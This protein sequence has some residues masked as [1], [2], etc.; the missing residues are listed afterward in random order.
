MVRA[1]N[2]VGYYSCIAA[3]LTLDFSSGLNR[4]ATPTLFVSGAADHLGGPPEIMAELAAS[5][6]GA[7]HVSVPHAARIANIQNSSDFNTILGK[8]LRR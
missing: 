6:P 8:F 1:T 2:P 4:I 3:F 7:E 5:V